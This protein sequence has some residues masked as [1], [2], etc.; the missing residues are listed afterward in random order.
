[1]LT[2]HQPGKETPAPPDCCT[3]VR[4]RGVRVNIMVTSCQNGCQAKLTRTRLPP[5]GLDAAGAGVVAGGTRLAT[6]RPELLFAAAAAAGA[7]AGAVLLLLELPWT[8]LA[9]AADSPGGPGAGA[10]AA[11]GMGYG[12]ETGMPMRA[13]SGWALE[14]L[15]VPFPLLS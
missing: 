15:V 5:R 8:A 1:M 9:K 2:P 6:A 10:R 14:P 4:V 3:P 7:G 13:R 11:G 12:E